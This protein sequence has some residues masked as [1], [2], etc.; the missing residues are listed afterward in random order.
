MDLTVISESKTN[1]IKLDGNTKKHR[2]HKL[3]GCGLTHW[4]HQIHFAFNVLYKMK[5]ILEL[6]YLFCSMSTRRTKQMLNIMIFKLE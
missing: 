2:K 3:P 6:L 4:A 1:K 5:L